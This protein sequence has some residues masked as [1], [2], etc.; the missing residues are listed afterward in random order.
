MK[1]MRPISGSKPSGTRASDNTIEI[2]TT[3]KTSNSKAKTKMGYKNKIG[4]QVR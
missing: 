2:N 4:R 1:V 3:L